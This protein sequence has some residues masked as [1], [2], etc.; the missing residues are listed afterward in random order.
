MAKNDIYLK[1]YLVSRIIADGKEI[2]GYTK[3][4]YMTN[5]DLCSIYRKVDFNDKDV[6]TVLASSDQVF[7]ARY[8][9]A[10]NVECFDKNRLAIYYYYLRKWSIKYMGCLYPNVLNGNN[11]W[12]RKLLSKVE[13]KTKEEKIVFDFFNKHVLNDTLLYN[14]FFDD[15]MNCRGTT[16]FESSDDLKGLVDQP[17]KFYDMN[18]FGSNDT[19]K[20]YDI[21]VI[22]N[23]LDWARGDN[24]K[25]RFA[26][27][28]L[29][30]LVRTNGVVICSNLVNREDEHYSRE[31]RIFDSNF[32]FNS[33]GSDY[34]YTKRG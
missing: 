19:N 6:L 29:S 27:D 8:L 1:D 28:N 22:S 2:D 15:Y 11:F 18:L 4:Y 17:L 9:G 14:L 33:F 23:I 10:K 20:T 32:D 25:Y 21:V 3:V 12:L 30:K 26:C 24:D 34:I 5:E 7:T 31:R 16:L 13:V